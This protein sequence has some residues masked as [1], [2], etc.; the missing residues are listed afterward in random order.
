MAT[1]TLL[2]SPRSQL[3]FFARLV[4]FT[5]APFAIVQIAAI[6]PV[7][8][9]LVSIA[10]ALGVFLAG[11]AFRAWATSSR[12]LRWLLD[13]ELAL[14]LHY[15]LRE[16]RP[17]AYYAF[18]PLLF[19]YWLVQRDARREFWL[20][21]GYTIGSLVILLASVA[22]QYAVDWYPSL[23]PDAFAEVVGITLAIEA[24]LVLWLLM[25]IATTVIGFHGSRRRGRLLVLLAVALVSIG[26]SIAH[27]ALRR[28]PIVSYATRERVLLR[29]AK[30]PRRARDVQVTALR[31]AWKS[32]VKMPGSLDEDGKV[33]GPPLDRARAVLRSFYKEDESY[34][35]D[36]WASPRRDPKLLVLYGVAF[37]G[38]PSVWI[39]MRIGGEEV[40]DPKQLP[41]G[42]FAAMRSAAQM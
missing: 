22:Y 9:A 23:G 37:W 28:D 15:Q 3:D 20:F 38:R 39:A 36:L 11:E 26:V 32:V 1:S 24:L 40:R 42:A 10:L 8:G 25:P 41:R 27:L 33:D 4:F 17:F 29:T 21:K 31:A 35:F 6:F 18:Y 7:G 30:S 34:A 12:L 13:R 16:P 2:T 19:P 5:V 14:T